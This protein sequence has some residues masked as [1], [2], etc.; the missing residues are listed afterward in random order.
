M[1]W[2]ATNLISAFLLPPFSLIL[3]GT[4]GFLLLKRRAGL[5]K[6]MIMTALALLYLLSIPLV[7]DALLQKL[8]S[9]PES[10][11]FDSNV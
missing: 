4:M 1:G 2:F 9:P 7:A 5:G 6:L 11:P 3:L 8:E 10:R